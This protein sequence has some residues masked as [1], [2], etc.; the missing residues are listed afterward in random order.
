MKMKR[1]H[2][3]PLSKQVATLLQELYDW[4][5]HG[6]LIFPSPFSNSSPISD[7]GLLNALRRMG[8]G[9][10]EMCVHG[11]RAMASTL[12]NECG[13]Y[14][15]DVIEA[16]LAHQEKN[17]VRNAYNH[18]QYLPERKIMMQ[19]WADWLDEMRASEN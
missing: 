10:E 19:E 13:R 17:A 9:R 18:V 12:L 3:V 2:V 8:Y 6:E 15:H 14:R 11:F 7:V 4:T 1:P 16:Q 5:G